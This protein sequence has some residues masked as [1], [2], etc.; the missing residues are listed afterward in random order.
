VKPKRV[1]GIYAIVCKP[2]GHT[3]SLRDRQRDHWNQIRHG[4]HVEKTMRKL[5]MEHGSASME[6]RV[7]E[8]VHG[9]NI[10]ARLQEAETRWM[11][12]T[13]RD[14]GGLLVNAVNNRYRVKEQRGKTTE[15]LLT[16]FTAFCEAR[17][18]IAK[19]VLYKLL[20]EYMLS[21][22][23]LPPASRPRRPAPKRGPQ[24]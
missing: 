18:L 6:W 7:L 10:D 20:T 3:T 17:E 16:E 1:A 22:R 12:A 21:S 4:G 9:S 11:F 23:T 24:A 14:I 2:T 19:D 8:E 15:A 5:C 13:R